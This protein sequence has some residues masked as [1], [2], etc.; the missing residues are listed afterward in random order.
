MRNLGSSVKIRLKPKCGKLRSYHWLP[1]TPKNFAFRHS[2]KTKILARCQFCLLTKFTTDERWQS[3]RD[4]FYLTRFFPKSACPTQALYS[5]FDVFAHWKGF[6]L[7]AKVRVVL[8]NVPRR[9]ILSTKKTHLGKL[10]PSATNAYDTKVYKG[11]RFN[12]ESTLDVQVHKIT[13]RQR[14]SNAGAERSF[15]IKFPLKCC[16]AWPLQTLSLLSCQSLRL[17]FRTG[18]PLVDGFVIANM[19]W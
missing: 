15:L 4:F 6:S 17:S 13:K 16:I 2:L 5:A 9:Q 1:Y 14:P 11:K 18:R 3:P 8:R 19:E 7:I 10:F 12:Q